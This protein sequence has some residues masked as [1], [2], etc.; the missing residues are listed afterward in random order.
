MNVWACGGEAEATRWEDIARKA[1]T[2]DKADFLH[3]GY[4]VSASSRSS[5]SAPVCERRDTRQSDRYSDSPAKRQRTETTP[6]AVDLSAEDAQF[7]SA[8]EEEDPDYD[9]AADEGA[10]AMEE[11]LP[12][13]Q[14][15]PSRRSPESAGA[16]QVRH[17]GAAEGAPATAGPSSSPG[18]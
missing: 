11:D 5:D 6:L 9:A 4:L 2:L 16:F 7:L 18:P 15:S 1:L 13:I 14:R 12:D 17:R 10:A 8:D 3:T